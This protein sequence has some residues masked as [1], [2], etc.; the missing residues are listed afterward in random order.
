MSK[1]ILYDTTLRD[2]TQG[3]GISFSADDKVKIALKRDKLGIHYIEGGW[4][5]SNP[6]DMDFFR[7]IKEYRLENAKIT[8]FGCTCKPGSSPHNDP[9]IRSI[10]EAG[11]QVATI[12]GKTWDFHVKYALKTTLA[13]NLRII[14]DTV[15]YLKGLGLEVIYDAEHFFDGF[16]S[17]P[18]YAL[19]TILEAEKAGA[20][21]VCLCD[22]NGGPMPMEVKEIVSAVIE[23]VRIP[24]GIHAHNDCELAVANSI[25]AVT[26]GATQVQG[27]INGFGERCGN[28]NLCSIIPNLVLKLGLDCMDKKNLANL[29]ELSRY[30][31]ELANV[32]PANNQ[33]YVGK[34]AFAHKGGIHVSALMRNSETYEHINPELVGNTR[35]VLV[36]ELS[37][38]SN[39]IYKAEELGL[40]INLNQAGFE[41]KKIL[42]EI[43]ELENTGFQF[44]GAEG[45][46]ELLMRKAFGGYVEPFQLEALRI[47][48][49]KREAGEINS[50]AV[51]KLRVGDEIV[52]TA[53]EGNGPV[54]ALDN[55]LRKALEE[56]YPCI[57][58]MRL[59]DYKVRVLDENAGTEAL[60]RVLAETHDKNLGSWG[61]VG[62]SSNVIEAS[63]QA[64][65]DSIAYGLLKKT[66]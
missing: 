61:T 23:K 11:V 36:S 60:V 19:A 26:A 48:L 45:S 58:E 1:V 32:H 39:I 46:F 18:E 59:A 33:P 35:R 29:T 27:T 15:A 34:S 9:N 47:I 3:E 17:N 5:G 56:F 52:H 22:T 41:A 43:K 30:V 57:R 38:M 64:I 24:V 54:N 50:E 10:Q 6:K 44:E 7:A 62:V 12:F 4:P 55:A 8:A 42:H 40:D 21:S 65:V 49:E 53:A 37:G 14:R 13:E 25:M 20:D 31:S 28:A 16:K 63:W 2:G 51:I 66:K